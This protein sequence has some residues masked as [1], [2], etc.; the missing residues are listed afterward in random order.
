MG[1]VI[2]AQQPHSDPPTCLVLQ[3]I[4]V[5]MDE[6]II[7]LRVGEKKEFVVPPE[8]GFGSYDATHTTNVPTDQLPENC[9]VGRLQPDI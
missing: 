2:Q 4:G 6:Q 9:E 7:G 5:G 3:D 8:K 1:Y